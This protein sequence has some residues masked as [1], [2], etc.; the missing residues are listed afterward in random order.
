MQIDL[1]KKLVFLLRR[2]QKDEQTF[3]N[4]E[5]EILINKIKQEL[6]PT[7]LVN[8]LYNYLYSFGIGNKIALKYHENTIVLVELN[9]VKESKQYNF[10][11][12]SKTGD[13]KHL[14]IKLVLDR[15]TNKIIAIKE[16]HYA[17][18]SCVDLVVLSRLDDNKY[19]ANKDMNEIFNLEYKADDFTEISFISFEVPTTYETHSTQKENE[20]KEE[21]R[22][23]KDSELKD[24]NLSTY[25][26]ESLKELSILF[27][28]KKEV[29]DNNLNEEE[30]KI[31]DPNLAEFYSKIK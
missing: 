10:I 7:I 4:E 24:K 19:D 12:P 14:K 6:I 28:A 25:T 29:P 13:I 16:L 8:Y 5:L 21:K 3:N 30:I 17:L 9:E 11:S 22:E 31:D 2:K 27:K 18:D 23:I 15:T 20:I 1:S 26:K